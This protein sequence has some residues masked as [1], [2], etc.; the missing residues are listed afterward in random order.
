M[1]IFVSL[2][3]FA[4]VVAEQPNCYNFPED[5]WSLDNHAIFGA[6]EEGAQ[7]PTWQMVKSS[8]T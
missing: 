5:G 8:F 3:L 4:F 1:K 2:W 6:I 7:A